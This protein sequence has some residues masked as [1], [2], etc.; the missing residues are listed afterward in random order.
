MAKSGTVPRQ[1]RSFRIFVRARCAGAGAGHQRLRGLS[2][3]FRPLNGPDRE[4]NQDC[5]ARLRRHNAG[6]VRTAAARYAQSTMGTRTSQLLWQS[7]STQFDRSGRTAQLSIVRSEVVAPRCSQH[8]GQQGELAAAPVLDR[9][10]LLIQ[11]SGTTY[12]P[13]QG[14]ISHGLKIRPSRRMRL[15]P[16]SRDNVR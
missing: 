6:T 4:T 1:N 10:H 11:A 2:F 12:Q 7:G 9:R 8:K 3:L 13:D 5:S 15:W 14:R 16:A